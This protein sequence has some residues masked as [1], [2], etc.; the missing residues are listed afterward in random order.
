MASDL[1]SVARR[2]FESVMAPLVLGGA[3]EPGHAIGARAA[4]ALGGGDHARALDAE[5]FDRVQAGRV[6][7]ARELAPLDAVDPPTP[8]EWAL[9]AA[10]HDLLQ[11]TNPGFDGLMR[12]SSAVR[13]LELASATIDRVP[14]PAHVGEA[15]SRH[16]WFARMLDAKRTDT[17]VSWWTG[18]QVFRGVVPPARL[19]LWRDLRRVST[20]STP[21]PVLEVEPLAVD[22]DQLAQTMAR[23]LE[24]TPLTALASC[25]RAGPAFA[26]GGATLALVR[27][28]P[29][30]TLALRA[31]QRLVPADV[32]AALG[33]AT[34]E[35]LG[36]SRDAAE[37][38]VSLLAERSLAAAQ[39]GAQQREAG[40][41][42]DAAFARA[43]GA[44]AALQQLASHSHG[45][46]AEERQRLA[47]QLAPL[48]SSELAKEAAAAMVGES[49]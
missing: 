1:G 13:V 30:R 41:K 8:P 9:A 20:V 28:R 43:L 31:V 26:W 6:R 47:A 34:R 4:L 27:S 37:P 33:R 29:G 38:A 12:R 19:Q 36:R 39:G 16:S 3:M 45:W 35:L 21:H 18:S 32:D 23:L 14:M 48:A 5:L 24:R 11:S 44:M 42:P 2:L 17:T 49:A 46:P 22:R 10:L 7:R 25:T 40:S 15:L